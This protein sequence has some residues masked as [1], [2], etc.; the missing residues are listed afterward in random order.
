MEVLQKPGTLYSL[1]ILCPLHT[2]PM[3]GRWA[4]TPCR[5]DYSNV[6]FGKNLL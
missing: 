4:N 1:H 2:F 3:V 6:S 5:L